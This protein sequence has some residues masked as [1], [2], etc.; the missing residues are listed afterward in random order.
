M[1]L[2]SVRPRINGLSLGVG[3]MY[4]EAV[5]HYDIASELNLLLQSALADLGNGIENGTAPTPDQFKA[6]ITA[7]AVSLCSAAA[8]GLTTD[9]CAVPYAQIDSLTGQY[10][11]AYSSTLAAKIQS[12]AAGD[13]C[14][15]FSFVQNNGVSLSPRAYAGCGYGGG[16]IA[17]PP[18]PVQTSQ[19][20]YSSQPS[21]ALDRVTPQTSSIIPPPQGNVL[22]P[23]QTPLVPTGQNA[24]SFTGTDTT[25]NKPGMFSET[26]GIGGFDIPMWALLGAGALAIFMIA[27]GKKQ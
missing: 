18:V 25:A 27:G 22:A 8:F 26:V 7:Q 10:A 4:D 23:P 20:Q 12:V 3:S 5:A 14:V 11:S 13:I 17:A 16:T 1:R 2:G 21:N 24:G 6:S 9:R 19:V 15:P